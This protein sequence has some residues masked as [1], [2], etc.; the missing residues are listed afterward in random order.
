MYGRVQHSNDEIEHA[1]LSN[2]LFASGCRRA[3]SRI[4]YLFDTAN[5]EVMIMHMIIHV[6]FIG[7]QTFRLENIDICDTDTDVRA[8]PPEGGF[9]STVQV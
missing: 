1:L 9:A 3:Q 5:S 8:N 4:C 7:E 6:L 2:K